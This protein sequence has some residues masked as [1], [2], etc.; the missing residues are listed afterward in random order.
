MKRI[1]I[2]L[3]LFQHFFCCNAYSQCISGDCKNGKGKFDFGWCVYE[4]EFKDEKPEGAGA[5]FYDDYTYTGTFK[6]GVE[7]GRGI[8][9]YKNGKQEEVMYSDGKK[10][11]YKPVAVNQ[12]EWKELDGH[13]P[14]CKSGNCVT[15][16]G[17]YIFESGNKYVGRFVNRKREG[18]GIFYY[19][20]GDRFEGIFS[21]NQKVKGKYFF[22]NGAVY[23]GDYKDDLEY[24]GVVTLN[25]NSVTFINGKA[26]IPPAPAQN[27]SNAGS[28]SSAVKSTG[29][30]SF[31][32]P[33][34]ECH[35]SGKIHHTVYG[36]YT[37]RD[38]YGNRSTSFGD[39][40]MCTRCF[41]KGTISSK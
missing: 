36:G 9:K 8:I 28:G 20:E 23:S 25:N 31:E 33:C 7:D 32:V 37:D 38:K 24:N 1:S 11:D 26:I 40:T 12:N 41:G 19:F 6:N 10:T 34:P 27:N 22:T 30:Q 15:G 39:Y 3:I 35:G 5:M 17:T 16:L 14:R 4:G 29:S 21:D 13:D 2:L 18:E